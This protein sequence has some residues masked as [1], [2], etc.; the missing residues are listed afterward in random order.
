[1]TTGQTDRSIQEKK[2]RDTTLSV[3]QTCPSV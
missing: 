2:Y 1:V 3:E